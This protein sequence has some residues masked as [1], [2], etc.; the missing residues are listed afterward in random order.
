M[1]PSKDSKR[2]SRTPESTNHNN[3]NSNT[4]NTNGGGGNASRESRHTGLFLPLFGLRLSP[5]KRRQIEA[6]KDRILSDLD[7]HS[8]Q[9]RGRA[10]TPASTVDVELK[11]LDDRQPN[12]KF[13]LRPGSTVAK[14][15]QLIRRRYQDKGHPIATA[16]HFAFH[17]DGKV[18][19][20]EDVL[21]P[22]SFKIWYR[23][24]PSS[25]EVDQ[26]KFSQYKDTNNQPI[27]PELA[28]QLVQAIDTGATVGDLRRKIATF[29]SISDPDRVLLVARGGTRPGQL[30]GDSWVVSEV[31]RHWL[32][33]WISYHIA[34]TNAYAVINGLGRRY[35]YHP[36][37][38]YFFDGMSVRRWQHH[39]DTRLFRN[40]RSRGKTGF[41]AHWSELILTL[42]DTRVSK[43]TRV[44]W[45]KTYEVE[46][47]GQAAKI[48]STEEAWLLPDET[49]SVCLDS[50]N[51]SV[52]AYK[53]TSGC[54]HKPTICN[55][56]LGQWIASELKTKMWDRI[57][58]PECPKSL[59]FADVKR[60]ASKS[61]FKRYDELATRAALGDIPNFRWCK[62]AKCSSGQID[63]VRCVRFK[64]K[65]CK[66]SHCIKHDVPW[67]SGETCEE[68]DKRNVQKKEDERASEAEITKSSK[69]CPSCNK[70]VHKFSGCNH[71]T[72]ICSHEWCYICLAPFQ[73][74]EHGF[75]YCRHKPECTERDPFVDLIDPQNANADPRNFFEAA[76]HGLFPPQFLRNRL[77]VVRGRAARHHPGAEANEP[78]QEQ[79]GRNPGRLHPDMFLPPWMQGVDRGM[80][81]G[82]AG[83]AD[84]VANGNGNGNG[85][86]PMHDLR[87]F[88]QDMRAARR[89]RA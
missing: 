15:E 83:I 80:F 2:G 77:R 69:K 60:N 67:H 88:A 9:R 4:S 27:P 51:L 20:P 35:V 54:D 11:P 62:S 29:M 17:A 47:P 63:D 1:A 82:V 19:N 31:K 85:R 41:N 75:L 79:I 44:C 21:L 74:N 5:R 53:I 57:K 28:T 39:L 50:K 34:R 87:L 61:V 3:N 58:C 32:C 43:T 40:V 14:L 6:E 71:I 59:Q 10:P 16:A 89:E 23:M 66:T 46:L 25:A 18:L 26:W 38:H 81:A 64:C 55:A 86:D 30:Q 7:R 73:R 48:F 76:N 56:C 24:S 65:A 45:G 78:G 68:Y 72:C 52:M 8:H 49:C 70:A 13:S 84:H 12:L 33:C 37:S 22:S 36:E 42:N